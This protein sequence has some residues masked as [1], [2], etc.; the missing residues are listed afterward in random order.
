[1]CSL[2]ASSRHRQAME[3]SA[4]WGIIPRCRL[5]L[6][7]GLTAQIPLAARP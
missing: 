6:T 5:V 4:R 1:M 3:R 7:F 2:T